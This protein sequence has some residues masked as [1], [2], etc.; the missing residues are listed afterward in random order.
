MLL[1][2]RIFLFDCEAKDDDDLDDQKIDDETDNAANLAERNKRDGWYCQ[3]PFA[4]IHWA[5]TH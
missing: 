2:R 4:A 1:S 3:A 5:Q